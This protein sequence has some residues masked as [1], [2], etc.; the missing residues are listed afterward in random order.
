MFRPDVLSVPSFWV[1]KVEQ[2][3]ETKQEGMENLFVRLSRHKIDKGP[4]E[5]GAV[6]PTGIET[7]SARG[8]V[9]GIAFR[10]VKRRMGVVAKDD[11][12][13]GQIGLL[14]GHVIN[15]T[16]VK[17]SPEVTHGAQ[18]VRLA[19]IVS[20]ERLKR[21]QRFPFRDEGLHPF[22]PVIVSN[23]PC[24]NGELVV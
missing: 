2:R 9:S 3:I 18:S 7:G 21:F 22:L 15:I 12:M 19:C 13:G 8:V 16:P 1:F 14:L 24:F 10:I 11:A 17:N 20:V 23:H 4:V 5:N 6:V